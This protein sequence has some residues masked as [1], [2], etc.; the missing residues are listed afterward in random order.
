MARLVD[1]G[2]IQTIGR[3]PARR[4]RVT[5]DVPAASL[6]PANMIVA[7]ADDDIPLGADAIDLRRQIHLPLARRL[8]IGYR[9]EFLEA[10]QPNQTFYL[11]TDIREYLHELG[12]SPVS[13][14]AAG[15]Y[16]RQILDRL[17]VDLAWSSSRLEGNT[18]TR[19]DTQNLIE[20]GRLAEGKGPL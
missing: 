14:R 9:R 10:Y 11:P 4:Y 19:L 7:T 8:P 3:G 2:A 16:A 18:Y 6:L 15:T 1:A 20:F 17:L 12:R 5:P 13:E